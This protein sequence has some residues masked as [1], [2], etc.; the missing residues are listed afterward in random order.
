MGFQQG[1]SG[2]NISS[3]NLD[4]IGN[5]IANSSTVGFKSSQAQFADVF[6]ASLSGAGG[7]P[8][9]LGAKVQAVA[10][11]FTQGNITTTSN[12]LDVA[13][14]GGGFYIVSPPGTNTPFYSRNGQFS[15]DANDFITTSEGYRLQGY[16]VDSAGAVLTGSAP[17]DIKVSKAKVAPQATG[18]S[19]LATGLTGSINLDSSDPI[20]AA[21]FNY[22]NTATYNRSTAATI[23]DSL[24]NQHT[25]TMYF[26]KSAANT[27]KVF[28]TVTNPSGASTAF[29]DLSAA[30]TVAQQTLTFNTAGA[31]TS[32]AA[33]QTITAA[34][35]GFAGGVNA[36]TFPV[37]FAGSTQFGSAFSVNS[38]A[39]DGY[40]AGE[41]SKFSVGTDGVI[42]GSYTN[43]ITRNLGGIALANFAN[44][45]GLQPVGNNRWAAT[46]NSGVPLVNQPGTG[47]NGLLQSSA[48][49]DS[50]VDMTQELVSMITAQRV[51]QANAQTIKTQDQ[52]LQTLVNLR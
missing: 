50:N 19:A 20:I 28:S 26:Q 34:Q 41:L 3:K 43:G 47:S 11:Q 51:Y 16:P 13:I 6:A 39:Q 48:V 52:V 24:G 42:L 32:A 37:N 31:L 1:L 8:V 38:L 30:G 17:Q 25:Y 44:P 9:G 33:N 15:L 4:V 23:Y 40:A 49:E 27:W 2:L 14:N 21:T 35:L 22:A 18:T 46:T 45:Q 7:S 5:N 10:Q 29:T 36:M 12:P